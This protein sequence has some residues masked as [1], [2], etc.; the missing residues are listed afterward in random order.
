MRG[1]IMAKII[2]VRHGQTDWNNIDRIQGCLDVPLN[3]EG[4]KQSKEIA[5]KLSGQRIKAIFSSDLSRSYTTAEEIARHYNL[6]V[7]RLKGLNELNQG[8]WQGLLL[9]EVKKRYKKQY[10]LWRMDPTLVQPPQGEDLK[11]VNTRVTEL[12]Q[13]FINKFKGK[14]ICVVSHEVILG[15]I[16]CYFKHMELTNLWAETLERASWEVIEV[17]DKN[18]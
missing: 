5:S 2:L 12:M 10:N 6:K 18:G 1:D 16:K 3:S 13:K 15:L 4:I 14:T 7:K 9:S 17:Q 11:E 8:L